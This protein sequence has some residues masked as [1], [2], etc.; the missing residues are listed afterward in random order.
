VPLQIRS[1][2]KLHNTVVLE[3]LICYRV[4]S[5]AEL[6]CALAYRSFRPSTAWYS[7]H[8]V[9]ALISGETKYQSSLIRLSFGYSAE[10]SLGAQFLSTWSI[11]SITLAHARSSSLIFR[12]A[13]SSHWATLMLFFSIISAG[14]FVG[15]GITIMHGSMKMKDMRRIVEL[16][17]CCA[18]G[19]WMDVNKRC[20]RQKA[21]KWT[22][23][24][25]DSEIWS[26]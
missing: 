21:K 4:S 22:C 1:N 5:I 2:L 18:S 10:L 3:D 14:L 9:I 25:A 24:G 19:P 16:C 12:F 15:V 8:G 13:N 7:G 6:Y 23:F 11:S 26:W 20:Y 17:W